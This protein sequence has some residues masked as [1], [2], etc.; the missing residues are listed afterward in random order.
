VLKVQVI[1]NKC[2][3]FFVHLLVK[4]NSNCTK[5]TVHAVAV[6]YKT[7]SGHMARKLGTEV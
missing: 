7:L 5:R 1:R 2:V 6:R 4:H 3:K